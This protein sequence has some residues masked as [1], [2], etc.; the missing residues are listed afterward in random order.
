MRER[1]MGIMVELENWAHDRDILGHGDT[2]P[3]L[4][5]AAGN[6]PAHSSRKL[7]V[8]FTIGCQAG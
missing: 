6:V 1:K 4:S 2:G 7:G 8:V 3:R 5:E